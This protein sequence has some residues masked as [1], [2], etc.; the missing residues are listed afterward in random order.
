MLSLKGWRLLGLEVTLKL[1]E[2]N[3]GRER[4]KKE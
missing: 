4:R 3:E 2:A 1:G